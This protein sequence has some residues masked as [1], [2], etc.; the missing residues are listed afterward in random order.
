MEINGDD[1]PRNTK[2]G[3]SGRVNQRKEWFFT[4]NNHPENGMEILEEKIAPLCEK[5]VWQEET[6]QNG[7]PHI[8][9]TFILFKRARWSEFELPKAIHW[10]ATKW[11]ESA[12]KYCHKEDTRSGRTF[13]KGMPRELVLIETLRP[14]QATMRDW[15]L[16]EPNDRKIVWIADERGNMGKTKFCKYMAAKHGA[17]IA[18]GGRTAD[19]AQILAGMAES[20]RDLNNPFTFILNVPRDMPARHVKYR[21]LE[22]VKDGLLTS[23]KYESQTLL[24]N[25]PHVWVFANEMPDMTCMT[26]DRW[27]VYKISQNYELER[28][29][30]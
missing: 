9:G 25:S 4:W 17:V 11:V 18:T 13:K 8:Q 20:G 21:A 29:Y 12:L 1:S 14:F 15:S 26:D 19:I 5:A 10:E 6:G 2:G 28:V 30:G 3:E 22:G 24:F 7:T 27:E 23:P 16:T